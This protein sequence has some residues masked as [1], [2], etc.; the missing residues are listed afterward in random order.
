ML[1]AEAAKTK[2]ISVLMLI[3]LSL[4]LQRCRVPPGDDE[5]LFEVAPDEFALDEP[6]EDFPPE[7][8]PL[9]VLPF[10]EVPPEVL[11]LGVFP[12]VVVPAAVLEAE[13]LP[14]A[15]QSGDL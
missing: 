6:P 11:L 12:P 4:D 10:A 1:F 3:V 9:D 15:E 13:E 8:P 5:P 2:G 7:L 14:F